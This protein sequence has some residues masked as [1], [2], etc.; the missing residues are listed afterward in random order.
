M[1]I[2]RQSAW[3]VLALAL[4]I[5]NAQALIV[6]TD[7]A[8]N[9]P[10]DAGWQT[11]DNGGTGLSPWTLTT[12]GN[13]Y[14]LIGDSTSSNGGI[15]INSTGN[16]AWGIQAYGGD[17][18]EAVRNLNS[19]LALGATISLKLDNGNIMPA[20]EVGVTFRNQ[21]TGQDMFQFS[22]V[23]GTSDYQWIDQTGTHTTTIPF[24]Y[25]GLTLSL[26]RT[27]LDSYSATIAALGGASQIITGNFGG[28]SD[29]SDLDQLRL[30]NANAGGDNPLLRSLPDRIAFFNSIE[31]DA[32]ITIPE[33]GLL[34]LLMTGT[35]VVFAR[36]YRLAQSRPRN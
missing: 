32:P 29:P 8:S 13:R 19:P 2:I 27:G 17:T 26:T 3:G 33:P 18:A 10:Y 31:I 21:A 4:L 6:A 22:F 12:G 5:T 25:N 14:Y 35:V 1:R 24:T 28:V 20:G 16:K 15:G 9:A 34:L 7:N 23:G 36:H 11:S 30:F